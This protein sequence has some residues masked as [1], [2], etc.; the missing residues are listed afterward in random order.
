VKKDASSL[1]QALAHAVAAIAI[2]WLAAA[3]S[4]PAVAPAAV[5]TIESAPVTAPTEEP[6]SAPTPAD[7]AEG[8][9]PNEQ[10]TLNSLEKVDDYP[11]Y[12]MHYNGSYDETASAGSEWPAST[13]VSGVSWTGRPWACSLFA[14]MGD[15]GSMVYGRNFDWEFSP[16]VLLF[17]DP[18]DGYASVSM[19]DMAYLGFDEDTAGAVTDLPLAE[20]SALLEAPFWPFDG[21]NERGLA[22]G[23]AAVPPGQP[24]PDPNKGMIG[25]LVVIREMLDHAGTVDEAAAILQSYNIDMEGGPDVHYLIADPS[26][27]SILVE[28]YGGE[29][30][31][32]PNE[33]PWH[34]A[35]N[36]LRA[37]VSELGE[38]G[39]WRY[40]RIGHRLAEAQGRLAMQDALNLLSEVSVAGTEWSV[41]Y[42]M[43]T[44]AVS[45]VMGRQYSSP[46][47]FHLDLAGQ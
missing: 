5:T 34:L 6:T 30:V 3:C 8:L 11:L 43:S 20:R 31:L 39:C 10:A 36:F 17:T 45:V 37:S 33:T 26:G 28:F 22:V 27:R 21:M 35:T 38:A 12:T 9:S 2:A 16:A 15:A 42:Q 47:T 25:S 7:G 23:M 4:R 41:A 13:A 32:I 24:P 1:R 19:V 46:H 44:L 18:P 29:T 40:D 14:A